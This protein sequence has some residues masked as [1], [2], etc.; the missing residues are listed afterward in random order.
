MT[1]INNDFKY[2][3]FIFSYSASHINIITACV[4]H[5]AIYILSTRIYQD[6]IP[7]ILQLY[8]VFL[9][10]DNTIE[11]KNHLDLFIICFAFM[12]LLFQII[13]NNYFVIIYI[14]L[15]NFKECRLLINYRNSK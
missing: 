10:S 12:E 5:F 9:L 3:Y 15:H 4:N 1:V 7:T 6:R 2:L 14:G 11:I 13:T 8:T